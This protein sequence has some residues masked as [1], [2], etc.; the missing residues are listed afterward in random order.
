[1]KIAVISGKGGTGKTFVAVNLA[2][3][4]EKSLY[5]DCDVEEPN[6]HLFFRPQ[7]EQKRRVAVLI[8]VIDLEKCVGCGL[9]ASFCKF[10]SLAIIK[11]KIMFFPETCHSCGGCHLLCPRQAI[12]EQRRELGSIEYGR[13]GKIITKTGILD[14]GEA[15]GVPVIRELL[16]ELP[17]KETIIIDSPPGS[18]CTVMESIKDAD[19]CLLVAE[20][21]LFGMDNLALVYELVKIYHKPCGLVVNKDLSDAVGR[22]LVADFCRINNLA[23]LARIP[24]NNNLAVINSQGKIAAALGE[25]YWHLFRKI[26]DLVKKEAS[27]S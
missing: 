15:S 1:M 4:A 27:I 8:P 24:F 6:G 7:L 10:N 18:A 16:N 25:K 20:P 5:I 14:L 21:T 11:G 2:Y 3:V 13:V 12:V 9:C 17:P 23:V 19:F 26:L 22:Q